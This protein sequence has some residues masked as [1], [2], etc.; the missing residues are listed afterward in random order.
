MLPP[1]RRGRSFRVASSPLDNSLPLREGSGVGVVQEAPPRSIRHHPHLQLLPPAGRRVQV[2]LRHRRLQR[3]GDGFQP[4]LHLT[5]LEVD[6]QRP[7][8]ALGENGEVAP[9]LRRDD[10]A[11]AERPPG[12]RQVLRRVG[13]NL[14]EDAAVRPALVGLARR[15]EEPR[16]EFQA[17]RDPAG[18]ADREAA[19]LQDRVVGLV[20]RQVG[21]EGD[22][23]APSAGRD[24]PAR[25]PPTRRPPG[26]GPRRSWGRRRAP[27]S[28]PRTGASRRAATR[29]SQPRRRASSSR[30]CSP[31]R[32][33]GRTG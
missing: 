16:P 1:I 26:A 18:V 25:R 10:R 12:D 2:V 15:V 28:R 20:A 33:A 5:G 27:A 23:V 14:Q 32:P 6:P 11:E 24:G 4:G 21:E 8:S 31:R 17:G 22:V 7:A 9:R 29:S 3:R 13:G 19:L 30:S